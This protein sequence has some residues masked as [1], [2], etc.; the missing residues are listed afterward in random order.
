MLKMLLETSSVSFILNTDIGR[1]IEL[2]MFHTEHCSKPQDMAN[3]VLSKR[4]PRIFPYFTFAYVLQQVQNI[5]HRQRLLQTFWKKPFL[6]PFGWEKNGDLL[7]FF[8]S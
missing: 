2:N 4:S 8:F 7:I 3:L 1:N 6:Y 5:L